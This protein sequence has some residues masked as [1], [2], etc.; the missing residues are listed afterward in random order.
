M[1]PP[2]ITIVPT[3][4]SASLKN[5]PHG[6]WGELN[7]NSP[8]SRIETLP[9]SSKMSGGRSLINVKIRKRDENRATARGEEMIGGTVTES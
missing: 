5:G 4:F 7:A 3:Q 9:L 6:Q 8:S 1:M 2:E